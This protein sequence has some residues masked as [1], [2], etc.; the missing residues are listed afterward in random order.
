MKC[1]NVQSTQIA[2][3]QKVNIMPGFLEEQQ[4][5]F[6]PVLGAVHGLGCCPW[7]LVL[8]MTTANS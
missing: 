1:Q 6:P 3:Y 4:K 7:P 2:I 8:S 5:N